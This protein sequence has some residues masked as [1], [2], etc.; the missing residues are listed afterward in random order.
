MNDNTLWI[1]LQQFLSRVHK[2]EINRCLTETFANISR[3]SLTMHVTSSADSSMDGGG[4][5]IK[6][7][8][9][10]RAVLLV[11]NTP[12][13]VCVRSARCAREI[14]C[15]LNG[16]SAQA[17]NCMTS[18]TAGGKKKKKKKQGPLQLPTASPSRYQ[19]S[20]SAL[21]FLT[22]GSCIVR[23]FYKKLVNVSDNCDKS[24]Q[25][26]LNWIKFFTFCAC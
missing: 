23:S 19:I 18:P 9:A 3:C 22:L 15:K 16:H 7:Q 13:T 6:W 11:S 12:H 10:L 4:I 24:F 5:Q 17:Y 25:F 1:R 21:R 20:H 2:R 14:L 26:S 8:E